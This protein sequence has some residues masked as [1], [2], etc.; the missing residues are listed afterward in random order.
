[1]A[2]IKKFEA[3]YGK[4][5]ASARYAL[6]VLEA[7]L[8]QPTITALGFG[9]SM[10]VR[11]LFKQIVNKIPQKEDGFLILQT[12]LSLKGVWT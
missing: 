12:V 6:G 9:S 5:S 3:F 10:T 1:M 7:K 8:A 4:G 2:G 11:D